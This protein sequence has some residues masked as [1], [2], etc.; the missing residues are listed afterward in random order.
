[1]ALVKKE[2]SKRSTFQERLLTILALTL[3][4]LKTKIMEVQNET[5]K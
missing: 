2:S 3:N 1:M 5:K 4:S